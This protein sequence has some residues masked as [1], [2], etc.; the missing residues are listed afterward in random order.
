M[1]FNGRGSTT[2]TNMAV[3]D[4]EAARI[5]TQRAAM[6][7]SEAASAGEKMPP[8]SKYAKPGIMH[9]LAAEQPT[10]LTPV[11]VQPVGFR[12][13]EGSTPGDHR[14]NVSGVVDAAMSKIANPPG[15]REQMRG[16]RN[17]KFSHEDEP[18]FKSFAG[19]T[20]DS[21]AGV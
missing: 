1:S 8:A 4:S 12:T 18:G 5:A 2:T 17:S 16:Q 19:N 13:L 15:P 9:G 7:E 3:G 11:H 14:N 20:A 6:T 10:E 21:D